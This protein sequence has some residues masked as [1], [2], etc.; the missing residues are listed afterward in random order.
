MTE[1]SI[2][3]A[4]RVFGTDLLFYSMLKKGP[5]WIRYP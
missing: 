5:G 1:D 3:R 4:G 2:N